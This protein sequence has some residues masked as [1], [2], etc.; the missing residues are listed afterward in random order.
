MIGGEGNWRAGGTLACSGL[1]VEAMEEADAVRVERGEN[2]N[3]LLLVVVRFGMKWHNNH[4]RKLNK[5]I[6][7]G[8]ICNNNDGFSAFVFLC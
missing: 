5:K 4:S 7:N 3:G 6:N 1:K 2:W 8:E